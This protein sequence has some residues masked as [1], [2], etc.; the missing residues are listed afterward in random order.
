MSKKNHKR[1]NKATIQPS[2]RRRFPIFV[3]LFVLLLIGIMTTVL[4]FLFHHSSKIAEPVAVEESIPQQ[5]YWC[6][7]CQQFH[8]AR[9]LAF[10]GS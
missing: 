5:K 2:K 7:H 3:S 9:S 4:I 10:D 8:T 6:A 1:K